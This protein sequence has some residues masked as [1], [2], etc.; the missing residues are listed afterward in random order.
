[1]ENNENKINYYAE[2]IEQLTGKQVVL[3]GED[4]LHFGGFIENWDFKII[5]KEKYFVAQKNDEPKN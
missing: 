5:K 1:M 4:I 3:M 2:A